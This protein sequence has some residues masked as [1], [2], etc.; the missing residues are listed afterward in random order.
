MDDRI[1][2][3]PDL[4]PLGNTG[5]LIPP[6]GVGTWQWG[7][8]VWWQYG[9]RFGDAEVAAAYTA[10]VKGG[11]R[12]FDTAE[13]YGMGKSE[14]LLGTH[15]RADDSVVVATKFFPFPWRLRTNDLIRALRG[16]LRRLGG[17][18]IDLYQIHW[19]T[20]TVPFE[21]RLE[22]LA[23]AMELGL[24]RSVGVSN[25]GQHQTVRA[26]RALGRHGI[27]LASNQIAYSL[28]NR[29]SERDGTLAACQEHGVAVIAY[30]PLAMGMLSGKYTDANPPPGLRRF[31]FPRHRLRA[32]SPL[33]AAVRRI[34]DARGK[35][36]SQV[37]LNWV[38]CKGAI[39]I[40]GAKNGQ[41]AEENC[42]ALGWRLTQ[43]EVGELDEV[44]DPVS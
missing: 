14:R 8:R 12:L 44:S 3:S 5:I 31:R 28:L 36:T 41:Q 38:I 4:V 43:D 9:S 29:S 37:A 19:P 40:P 42:G 26:V 22:G 18:P 2:T 1:A 6:L 16:S 27:P 23:S 24:T 11:A 34:A 20:G 35:T 13:I 17:R 25:Y 15:S 21:R 39:P 33:V 32:I 7:D 10:A 30:S